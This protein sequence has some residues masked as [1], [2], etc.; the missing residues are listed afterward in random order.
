MRRVGR[1]PGPRVCGER[2]R[3]ILGTKRICTPVRGNNASGPLA[4]QLLR[5][6]YCLRCSH[7]TPSGHGAHKNGS[8]LSIKKKGCPKAPSLSSET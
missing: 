1:E 5:V 7:S 2:C 6:A 3:R 4:A 8:V